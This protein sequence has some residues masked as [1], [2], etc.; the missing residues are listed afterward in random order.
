MSTYLKTADF[1]SSVLSYK[2]VEDIRLDQTAI[3]DVLQDSGTLVTID[4]DAT[5]TQS[6]QYLKLKFTSSD[7]TPGTTVPDM[8]V[9]CAS[10][11]RTLVELPGGM[12][13]T[14]LSAWLV[15]SE[16]DNNAA[17]AEAAA[18]RYTIVRFVTK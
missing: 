3:V 13:F 14:S 6:H 11:K 16:L 15:S 12:S 10:A 17:N 4:V 9:M 1:D 5:A 18:G 7:V 8:V 2:I